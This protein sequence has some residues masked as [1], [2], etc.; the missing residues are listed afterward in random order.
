MFYIAQLNESD[1]GFA[2]LKMLLANLYEER[3]YLFIKQDEE[4]GPYSYFDLIK[5]ARNY[6][7]K[8]EGFK[9]KNKHTFKDWVE[10]PVIVTIERSGLNHAVTI[11]KKKRNKLLILDPD[12]SPK[13]VKIKDFIKIW[14]GTL[15]KVKKYDNDPSN[16]PHVLDFEKKIKYK[17]V[18]QLVQIF[19]S[20]AFLAFLFFLNDSFSPYIAV[21]IGC[22]YLIGEILFRHILI[23]MMDN[24]D[25]AC[26]GK[27]KK[28]PKNSHVFLTR[29]NDYK[30]TLITDKISLISNIIMALSLIF[31]MVFNGYWNAII[32]FTIIILTIVDSVVLKPFF[33]KKERYICEKEKELCNAKTNSE[34]QSVYAKIKKLSNKYAYFQYF[35]SVSILILILLT[36]FVILKLTNTISLT[37]L[38]FYFMISL[39]LKKSISIIFEVQ[40]KR[41]AKDLLKA[42][43]NNLCQ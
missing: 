23:K 5:I 41:R 16:K 28:V 26:V 9:F 42:K 3:D 29:L 38:L 6:N 25:L 31:L 20:L 14:D 33:N 32:V 8:L 40:S 7:V 35:K 15:L 30:Q 11:I 37:S 39:Y 12:S 1:C 4:H 36:V 13:W 22:S 19:I 43:L 2:S 10:F 17:F 24:L 21:I 27:L 34:F 18:S